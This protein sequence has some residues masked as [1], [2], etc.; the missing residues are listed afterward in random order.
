V[1][2]NGRGVQ[3]TAESANG[4]AL[5]VEG[6]S[7]FSTVSSGTIPRLRKSFAV[8]VASGLITGKSHIS[9]TL[10]SDPTVLGGDAAISWVQRDPT[11]N[12]FTINLT[13][14]VGKDTTFTYFIVEP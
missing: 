8:N 12:R 7:S 10:T 6:K 4:T 14:A 13:K 1:T 11:N 5:R 3:A 2:V 9:V